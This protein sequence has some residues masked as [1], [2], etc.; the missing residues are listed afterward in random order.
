LYVDSL[1][2]VLSGFQGSNTRQARCNLAE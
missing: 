2:K 1:F